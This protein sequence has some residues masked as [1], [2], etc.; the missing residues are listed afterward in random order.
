[1]VTTK[2]GAERRIRRDVARVDLND[3]INLSEVGAAML[4]GFDIA[5]HRKDV[6]REIRKTKQVPSIPQFWGAWLHQLNNA[7]RTMEGAFR[8][9][10]D[11]SGDE[12]AGIVPIQISERA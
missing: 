10:L 5:T 4:R 1:M 8:E 9:I 2:D 12:Q 11:V 6:Q 3:R 7:V